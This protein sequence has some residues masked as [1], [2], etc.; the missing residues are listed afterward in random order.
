V[1]VEGDRKR[2]LRTLTPRTSAHHATAGEA[3]SPQQKTSEESALRIMSQNLRHGALQD[4]DGRGEDRWPGIA[5]IISDLCPDILC[6]Q[7]VQGW[8][9]RNSRQVYRAERDLGMR[10]AGWIPVTES[11]GGTLVMYRHQVGVL[12][13]VQWEHHNQSTVYKGLCV[14]VFDTGHPVPLAVASVHLTSVSVATAEQEALW[15]ASRVHR[16]GGVGVMAGDINHHPAIDDGYP[17]PRELPPLNVGARFTTDATGQ[18]VPDRRVAHALMRDR[19]VDAAA[20]LAH[21]RGDTSYLAPASG[22]R[23]RVDQT[24][25]SQPLRAAIAEYHRVPHEYSDHNAIAVDLNLD[26]VDYTALPRVS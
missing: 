17:D 8:R 7:E 25:V 3:P 21:T 13:Q 9:E 24:W 20:H 15:I 12:E 19:M 16:Y 22:G 4:A 5:D 10:I 2:Q 18:L 14:P 1:A 26:A 6:L 23:L 11:L